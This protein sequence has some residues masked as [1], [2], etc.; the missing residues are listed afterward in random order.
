MT[1]TDKTLYWAAS[2]EETN[3]PPSSKRIVR[4]SI[5]GVKLAIGVVDTPGGYRRVCRND[6][7]YRLAPWWVKTAAWFV[8]AYWVLRAGKFNG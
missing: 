7:L 4:M 6:L 3:P 2:N 1:W 5:G 8:D